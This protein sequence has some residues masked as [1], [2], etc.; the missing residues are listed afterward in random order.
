MC[1]CEIDRRDFP[2]SL[3]I[4]AFV[5][6]TKIHLKHEDVPVVHDLLGVV[7]LIVYN[8]VD[9]RVAVSLPHSRHDLAGHHDRP[10]GVL[11][12]EQLAT[13]VLCGMG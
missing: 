10:G 7:V 3:V 8:L 6:N 1:V 11:H 2:I 4:A 9:D 12:Q 13:T 5:F